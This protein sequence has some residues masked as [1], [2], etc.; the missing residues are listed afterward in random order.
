MSE[1]TYQRDGIALY[2]G[3]CLDILP[4]LEPGSV[5]CVVTDPPY[6][7]GGAYRSDRTQPTDAKYQHT[8]ETNRNYAT[9]SGDNR[10]QRSFERWCHMWMRDALFATR[11]G[12]IFASFIDWRNVSS[13]IDAVQV[14]GWV[15]RGLVPWHKGTD[16][17]PRKGWFRA[18]VEY[19]VMGSCGPILTGHLAPGECADGVIY[20]RVNGIEKLHQ[21]GKPVEVCEALIDMRPDMVQVLDPFMGS[22][23]TGVACVQTGRRFIGIEIERKHF[24]IAVGRIEAAM[25]CVPVAEAKAGQRGLFA[26]LEQP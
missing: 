4:T 26:E 14:A 10:D 3:D 20:C 8:A 25:D 13:M 12:G 17:R 9:F 24:D 23:T 18:N 21:T 1:P 2:H 22:G 19:L 6:S 16:Q 11:E 5:D 7:S 15:Y